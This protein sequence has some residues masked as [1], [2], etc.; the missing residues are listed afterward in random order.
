MRICLHDDPVDPVLL[1]LPHFSS[2]SICRCGI[3]V[4]TV[5]LTNS[6]LGHV[7]HRY[8][9]RP[10]VSP[11]LPYHASIGCAVSP[12][13]SCHDG[14]AY[15]VSRALAISFSIL[16]PARPFIIDLLLFASLGPVELE[17][18]EEDNAQRDG[19]GPPYDLCRIECGAQTFAERLSL[20]LRLLTR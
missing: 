14:Q 11:V 7:L 17:S 16:V 2:R 15:S 1:Q 6:H 5:G 3:H 8:G 19:N 9:S 18:S 20:L 12:R 10:C 13:V 4:R